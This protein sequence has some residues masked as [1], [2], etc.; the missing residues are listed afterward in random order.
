MID[1]EQRLLTPAEWESLSIESRHRMSLYQLTFEGLFE[2]LKEA[3]T[4][5]RRAESVIS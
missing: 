2:R 1:T 4:R 3:E 5:L